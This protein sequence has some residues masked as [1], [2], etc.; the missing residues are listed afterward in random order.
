MECSAAIPSV[1][2]WHPGIPGVPKP[3]RVCHTQRRGYRYTLDAGFSSSPPSSLPTCFVCRGLK[4][5]RTLRTRYKNRA[6]NKSCPRRHGT[7]PILKPFALRELVEINA[8]TG[9]YRHISCL[10]TALQKCSISVSWFCDHRACML[11]S[12]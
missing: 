12:L 8:S 1:S 11:L 6:I 9:I 7:N 10:L 4:I 2:S 5:A 3:R